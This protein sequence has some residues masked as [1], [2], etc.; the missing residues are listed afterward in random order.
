M[1][2]CAAKR[3]MRALR[4]SAVN[5][6][7]FCNLAERAFSKIISQP[8]KGFTPT[9]CTVPSCSYRA[10]LTCAHP[11]DGRHAGPCGS[12]PASRLRPCAML[13]ANGE[14]MM[15]VGAEGWALSGRTKGCVTCACVQMATARPPAITDKN[16]SVTSMNSEV[17]QAIAAH[18]PA[19]LHIRAP[20][21]SRIHAAE[22]GHSNSTVT[23]IAAL[24]TSTASL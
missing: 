18:F 3:N 22:G 20:R 19:R 11:R 16:F 24:V 5:E 9:K 12:V 6:A 2:G 1:C 17:R 8:R 23:R 10:R 4:N 13:R 14:R 15:W 7:V 21:L